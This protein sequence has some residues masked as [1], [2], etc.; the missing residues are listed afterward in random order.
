ME[1]TTF[2]FDQLKRDWAEAQKLPRK[3][4]YDKEEKLLEFFFKKFP[5]FKRLG[6]Q[7]QLVCENGNPTGWAFA[8]GFGVH[9]FPTRGIAKKAYYSIRKQQ[10]RIDLLGKPEPCTLLEAIAWGGH[11]L[12]AQI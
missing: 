8:W 1:N 9:W 5:E 12:Q 4:R 2:D 10:E 6:W 7:M 11:G 3:K